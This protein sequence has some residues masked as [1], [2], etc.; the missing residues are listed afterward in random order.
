MILTNVHDFSSMPMFV[1]EFH[2]FFENHP[3]G[4]QEQQNHLYLKDLRKTPGADLGT[5]TRIK[6]MTKVLQN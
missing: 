6:F 4:D 1:I 5:L 3:S 2:V